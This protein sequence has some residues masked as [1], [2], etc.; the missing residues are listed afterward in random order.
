MGSKKRTAS[1]KEKKHSR[2]S[3]SRD[4]SEARVSSKK[5]KSMARSRSTDK[6]SSREREHSSERNRS[7]GRRHSEDKDSSR[8]REY[9]ENRVDSSPRKS[10]LDRSPRKSPRGDR[11]ARIEADLKRGALS[12]WDLK[13]ATGGFEAKKW[14]WQQ[15]KEEEMKAFL[16]YE[17]LCNVGKKSLAAK[18]AEKDRQWLEEKEKERMERRKEGEKGKEREGRRKDREKG[19]TPRDRSYASGER[20]KRE[21]TYSREEKPKRIEGSDKRRDSS[22]HW[23]DKDVKE[24]RI[25]RKKDDESRSQK[26]GD[27]DS[28][29]EERRVRRRE[30]D[31]EVYGP[32]PPPATRKSEER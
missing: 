11:L 8:R 10:S 24:E 27:C 32:R 19:N 6:H 17:N 4:G 7:S 14:S 2:R 12:E 20:S 22:G 21:R 3:N 28:G 30:E 25:V 16:K 13:R 15:K 23:D 26:H 31:D 29:K 9:S 1:K 5:K 18:F